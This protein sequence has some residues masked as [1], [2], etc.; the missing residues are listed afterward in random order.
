MTEFIEL[1]KAGSPTNPDLYWLDIKPYRIAELFF[2]K[3]QVKVSNQLV[4]RVLK[5]LGY[6]YRKRTKQLAT[7]SY[8]R[9][10]GQFNIIWSIIL[11]M[12]L[13]NSAWRRL[14]STS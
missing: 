8:A 1:H 9:R 4:K 14:L 2:E 6:A 11:L 5:T 3:H 7:G 12:N 13:K 10:D